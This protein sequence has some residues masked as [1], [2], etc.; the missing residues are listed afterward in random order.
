M[1]EVPEDWRKAGVTAVFKK[2]K[3]EELGKYWPVRLTSMPGK[4]MEQVVLNVISKQVEE[5]K[6]IR[7]GQHGFSKGK[8]CLTNLIVCDVMTSWVDQGR[9]VDVVYFGFSKAFDNLS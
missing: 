8:S 6:V 4:V 1:R 7:S 9:A 5:K 3:K 2:G